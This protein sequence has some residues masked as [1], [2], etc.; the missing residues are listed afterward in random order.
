M[1]HTEPLFK[2]HNLLKVQNIY[3]IAVFEHFLNQVII[4]Y[5]IISAILLQF[6]AGHQHYNFRNPTRLLPT[7]KHEFSRQSLRYR[8]IVTLNETP[9][10]ILVMATTQS[11]KCFIKFIRER[12]VA[13][14]SYTCNLVI[15]R[16]CDGT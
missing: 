5:L 2:E 15:C 3:Y 12:I 6:S 4:I 16:I 13:G 9:D 11:Q 8:L 7:I 10:D 1:A 14:Y